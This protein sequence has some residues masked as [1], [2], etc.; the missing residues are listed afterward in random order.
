M[1]DRVLNEEIFLCKYIFQKLPLAL[2]IFVVETFQWKHWEE[3][4]DLWWKSP[5]FWLLLVLVQLSI[6]I[7]F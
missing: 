7:I 3:N 6:S 5:I 1:K 2:D 4:N